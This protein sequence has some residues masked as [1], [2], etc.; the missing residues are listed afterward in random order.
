MAAPNIVT[1]NIGRSQSVVGMPTTASVSS[2][3]GAIAASTVTEIEFNLQGVLAGDYISVIPSKAVATD[4]AI[5]YSYVSASNKIKIAYVKTSAS[6]A[7]PAADTYSV[8]IVRPS[9]TS[10][11]TTDFQVATGANSGA[12]PGQYT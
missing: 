11:L 6:T 1:K 7:T 3:T 4:C 10:A 9:P 8:L 12:V 5:T 2:L